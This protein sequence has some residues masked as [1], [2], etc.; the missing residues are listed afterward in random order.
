MLRTITLHDLSIRCHLPWTGN[1]ENDGGH[2]T[3]LARLSSGGKSGEWLQ[4]LSWQAPD[5]QRALV[6]LPI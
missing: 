6:N 4:A 5:C 2:R 1:P 3:V